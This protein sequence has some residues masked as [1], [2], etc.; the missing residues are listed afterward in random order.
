MKLLL[1]THSFLWF[2]EGNV[3]LSRAART[4]IEDP[5]NE[6]L[7]SI[8]SVWEMAIKTS[9]GRLQLAQPFGQFISQQL[10]ENDIG[11]LG[12]TFEHTARIADLP[13][14][15]KDPFDRLII[16]QG[17]VEMLPIISVDQQFDA[18]GVERLW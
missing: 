6:R 16:A 5:D 17:L 3:K 11:L 8:A 7:V 18:Y 14:H 10:E 15:H 9:M 2:I 4:L 13:F 1:D 12:V